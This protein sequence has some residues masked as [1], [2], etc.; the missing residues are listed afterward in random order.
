MWVNVSSIGDYLAGDS[1]FY[2]QIIAQPDRI[3][4]RVGVDHFRVADDIEHMS[5]EPC[6]GIHDFPCLIRGRMRVSD[7]ASHPS[8]CNLPHEIRST[9]KFWR[10]IP[11]LDVPAACFHKHFSDFT[12]D[13]RR[14]AGK[15]S[16]RYG[17]IRRLKAKSTKLR[18]VCEISRAAAVT[19]HLKRN[20]SGRCKQSREKSCDPSRRFELRVINQIA[21]AHGLSP[22]TVS[23]LVDKSR[24]HVATGCVNLIDRTVDVTNFT[25]QTGF[26]QDT[27]WHNA[28]TRQQDASVP[29]NQI[30]F[31]ILSHRNAYP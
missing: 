22:Q 25:D 19:F 20:L 8:G 30:S 26:H 6:P 15:P 27:P 7:A 29:D 12:A 28:S 17:K 10:D 31:Q 14:V 11:Y 1:I 2:Q 13:R 9:I 3:D 24:D 5:N 16:A 18:Q 4:I 23:V 21:L